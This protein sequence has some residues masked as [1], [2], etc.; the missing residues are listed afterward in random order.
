MP[1]LWNCN[2]FLRLRFRLLKSSGSSSYLDHKK[3]ISK[4]NLEKNLAFLQSKLFY[5]EKLISFIK[6]IVNEGNVK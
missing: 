1:V 4:N 6:F 5:K 2:Y 3:Q